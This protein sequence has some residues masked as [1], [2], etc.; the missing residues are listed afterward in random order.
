MRG[1]KRTAPLDASRVPRGMLFPLRRGCLATSGSTAAQAAQPSQARE[2]GIEALPRGVAKPS[3]DAEAE[4]EPDERAPL[5]G[6]HPSVRNAKR[7]RYEVARSIVSDPVQAEA[8]AV[9]LEGGFYAE[10]PKE[11]R[12]SLLR[13]YCALAKEAGMTPFPLRVSVVRKVFGALKKA[14]YRSAG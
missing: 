14:G 6:D 3:F 4:V 5:R 1:F 7:G 13:T 10:S 11:P 8:A 2:S 9:E 12:D